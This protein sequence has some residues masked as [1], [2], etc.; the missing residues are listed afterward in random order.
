MLIGVPGKSNAFAI[1][2]KLGLSDKIIEKARQQI[3]S[4]QESFEDVL[5]S[6]ETRRVQLERERADFNEQ[7]QKL[8]NRL[9]DLTRREEKLQSQKDD[10]LRNANE[11]A[12][13]ILRDAKK[14]ADETI[15]S[16]QKFDDNSSMKEME[17]KRTKVREK[18]SEKDSKLTLKAPK[19]PKGSKVK[20]NRAAFRR[21]RQ[22]TFHE[23]AR[24]RQFQARC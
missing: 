5:S 21:P 9:A 11:Q 24:N 8:E 16:F 12:R 23:S 10:I 22:G 14:V 7:K 3:S 15:R 20:S 1:S 6:L 17:Q 2:E 19:V 13:D 18:I 4:E